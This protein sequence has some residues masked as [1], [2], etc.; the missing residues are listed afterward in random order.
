MAVGGP[1]SGMPPQSGYQVKVEMGDDVVEMGTHEFQSL[2]D[3]QF[4]SHSRYGTVKSGIVTNR[5]GK[6]V[7]QVKAFEKYIVT[8]N[9]RGGYFKHD[10]KFGYQLTGFSGGT[11]KP[12]IKW[13]GDEL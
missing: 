4:R 10:P 5:F 13:A 6:Q 11:V 12:S 3:E 1:R 8:G 9:L 2:V 7:Q